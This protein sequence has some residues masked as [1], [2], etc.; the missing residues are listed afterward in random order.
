MDTNAGAK[1]TTPDK[2]PQ[3]KYIRTFAGDIETLKKGGIPDLKP[4]K[5]LSSAVPAPV[6]ERPTV[7]API[8]LPKPLLPIPPPLQ[9]PKPILPP[10]KPVLPPPIP[11]KIFIPPPIEQPPPP[12]M[13]LKT[14]AGDFS[15]RMRD[16]HSSTATVLAAEQDSVTT[17]PQPTSKKSSHNV[18]YSIAGVVLL[19][20]A[21]VAAYYAY[22]IYLVKMP[23]VIIAPVVSAPIFVDERNKLSGTGPSLFQ[24]I[25]QSVAQPITAGSVR[26]LYIETSTTTPD[27]VFSALHMPAPDILLRNVN[28]SGT[29]AGVVS[30]GGIQSPFFILSVASYAETFYGMLQW[31]PSMPNDFA[32]LFPPYPSSSILPTAT[33]TPASSTSKKVG[34]V[35]TITPTSTPTPIMQLKFIDDSVANHD[36]RIYRDAL[37]KSIL[38]YGY[39]NQGTLVIA[40]DEAAFTEIL[41]RLATSRAQ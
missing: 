2:N 33:S 39:W 17:A 9:A 35:A 6:A 20:A 26:L 25:T 27:S 31:E 10:P 28:V 13:P 22:T 4:L 7:A 1:N 29:M 3:E 18:F 16:T 8:V 41:Q 40:R 36:V 11:K 37:G 5:R 30:V 21:G 15:D 23:T 12:V 38:L 34:N 19:I 24:A 32:Q 14:Y